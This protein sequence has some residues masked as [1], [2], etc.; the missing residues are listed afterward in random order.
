MKPCL[1][2]AIPAMDEADFLPSSMAALLQQAS[3]YDYHI[4]LCV[5][6]P[7]K[8]WETRPDICENNRRSLAYLHELKS[9]KISIIDR[10]SP[11]QGWMGKHSGVGWARKTLFDHILSLAGSQDI[12]LSLDADTLVEPHYCQAVGDYFA[13]HPKIQALALPYY[14]PLCLNDSEQAAKISSSERENINRAMLS[15]EMYMRLYHLNMQ[16]IA[17]PFAFTAIGSAMAFRTEALRKIG[18]IKPLPSGEDFY[19]LQ[20]FCKTAKVG[21]DCPTKVMPAT[22][23][24]DR[25]VFG[26]GPALAKACAGDETSYPFYPPSYF[27]SIAQAYTLIRD[28]Y[29]NKALPANDFL[30]FLSRQFKDESLWQ[31]LRENLK[32]LPHFTQGFHE[33]ADGLRIL[34]F[35]KQTYAAR[36]PLEKDCLQQNLQKHLGE[37]FPYQHLSEAPM[38]YL[39][40]LREK[41]F[42]REL[43]IR[44]IQG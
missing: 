43:F 4:Y 24:S 34:Q 26:T 25:V 8:Y 10:S 37:D 38:E 29:E 13:Q 28:I 40:A 39:M 2:I 6:Q 33:K 1:H 44:K 17:S 18:G 27:E 11:G 41:L 7:E 21:H 32:D 16:A 15:Y 23:F 22:R 14:H 42:Q 5:N 31:P 9:D 20:K 36:K 35:L 3:S 12:I 19:L 30:D